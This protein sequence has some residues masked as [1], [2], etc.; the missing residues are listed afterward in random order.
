MR[1]LVLNEKVEDEIRRVKEYAE[2]H[3]ITEDQFT[4]ML[5]G[6]A[7]VGDD[8]NFV[9]QIPMGF[10]VVY[11]I[12]PQPKTGLCRHLSVS[13]PDPDKAPHPAAMETIAKNFGFPPLEECHLWFEDLDNG[14]KAVNVLVPLE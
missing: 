5:E 11:S 2:T 3:P 12:E 9:L 14:G 6:E 13:I 8:P 4:K 1:A 7:P 10:K